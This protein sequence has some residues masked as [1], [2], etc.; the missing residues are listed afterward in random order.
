MNEIKEEV[1]KVFGNKL[2]IRVCGIC[3]KD[4]TIL[5][6]RHSGLGKKGVLWAPPGGGI[7]FGETAEQ[8]LVREFKE[9]TGLEVEVKRFLFVHEFLSIPLHAIELFFE[10]AIR[11]GTIV[12]GKDPEL[13]EEKQIIEDVCFFS[14]ND[15]MKED[16]EL[17][18]HMLQKFRD[19]KALRTLTGYWKSSDSEQ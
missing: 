10:V 12:P 6:V 14:E 1:V 19:P 3:F 16:P 5:L 17:F 11:S 13:A 4:N 7:N 9:E 8:T 2:R 18:H 15:I